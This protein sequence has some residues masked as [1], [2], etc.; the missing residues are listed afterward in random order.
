MTRTRGDDLP[1][2]GPL[3]FERTKA[4]WNFLRTHPAFRAHPLA[5]LKRLMLWRVLTV[6]GRPCHV[7]L[8]RWNLKVEVPTQWRGPGKVIFA[9]REH[10]DAELI[11]L[12]RFLRSDDVFIDVGANLG[13]YSLVASRLVGPSGRVLAIEPFKPTFARLE[14]NVGLNGAINVTAVHAGISDQNETVTLTMHE[15]DS[16]ISLHRAGTAADNCADG[17][18][19]EAYTL[20]RV[21]SDHGFERVDFIKVDVEGAEELVLRGAGKTLDRW[22]PTILFEI[23]KQAAESVGLDVR[24]PYARLV[25]QGYKIFRISH[26]G[27][28]QAVDALP[29]DGNYFAKFPTLPTGPRLGPDWKAD[30]GEGFGAGSGGNVR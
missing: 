8:A 13:L 14:R 12:E 24:L 6:F 18:S 17:E 15:D 3:L 21:L 1:M 7:G 26:D 28:L 4:H 2:T 9:F 11:Y 27:R 10:Y 23:N 30:A 22:H 19:V 16:R 29:E 5:V 20:D 25:Q